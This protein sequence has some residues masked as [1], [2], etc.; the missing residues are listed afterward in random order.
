MIATVRRSCLDGFPGLAALISFD[1]CIQNNALNALR[2]A[3][4]MLYADHQPVDAKG[5]DA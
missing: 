2:G 5:A 1:S 4:Q 3:T